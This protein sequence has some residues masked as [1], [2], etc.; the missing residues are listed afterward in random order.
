MLRP[1]YGCCCCLSRRVARHALSTCVARV[2]PVA[3]CI[4]FC[5]VFFLF[6]LNEVARELEDPFTTELGVYLGANRLH[7]PRMQ[8]HF[9]ERCLA[10][11]GGY[12]GGSDASAVGSLLDG[13]SLV[14]DD[15]RY[16]P[17]LAD[18]VA[19]LHRDAR[20][21]GGGQEGGKRV[22]A[23][24]QVEVVLSAPPEPQ[25]VGSE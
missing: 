15:D 7:V 25:G 14:D 2:S 8:A 10:V 13:P 20:R 22:L 23:A 21:D 17:F 4:S 9:D 18:L 11:G 24:Q 3:A 5:C 12:V 16:G 19:P 1:R 6:A